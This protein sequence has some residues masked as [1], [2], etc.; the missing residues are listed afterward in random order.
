M[1][2][3][4][5]AL[6]LC[7]FAGPALA[8]AVTYRG[9]LNSL[10]I[11]VEFSEAPES[12]GDG[13]YAR[14]FYVDNGID[15][16]MQATSVAP[17]S[18]VLAV[19][20]PCEDENCAYGGDIPDSIPQIQTHWTLSIRDGGASLIGD[21]GSQYAPIHL[22]RTG[23]RPYTPSEPTPADLAAFATSLSYSGERLT[24]ETSPYDYLKVNVALEHS[25]RV[26]ANGVEYDYVTD[27]RT[28]FK[29]PRLRHVSGV[30]TR[31]ANR[32]LE[33]RDWM[34][35]LEALN[36]RALMYPGMG[37]NESGAWAYG[38]L[39]GYED[40]TVTV[41][42]LSDKVMSWTEAGSL[43]CGGAHPYNHHEFF[44]LDVQAGELLDL[45]RI[46]SGWV[47]RNYDGT[48][49]D[50][51]TA[52]ANPSDY[53]WLPD[54]TLA[55]FVKSHRLTDAEL[56]FSADNECPIDE[57]IDSNLAI[58]FKANGVV[59]FSLDGLPNVIAACSSDLLEAPIADLRELLAP[60]AHSYFPSLAS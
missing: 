12:A 15:V 21:A 30:G 47:P 50:L 3:R 16:P 37:W 45:S 20:Q 46:F 27:P 36:C 49:V 58:G 59:L 9:D 32:F 52:R 25:G 34:M 42:Y 43:F 31:P 28:L 14:Y 17:D 48:P 1:I 53:Q 22:E 6:A 8:D 60:D 54:E 35:R 7:L 24:R 5:A 40:E 18:I 44:N 2:N 4:L 10:P 19:E 33:Q 38:T 41:T 56:G 55:T 23:S 11:V 29:Y 39:G 57:L 51:E 13:L 26:S